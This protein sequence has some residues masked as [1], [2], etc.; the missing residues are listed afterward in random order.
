MFFI[1][2]LQRSKD[3]IIGCLGFSLKIIVLLDAY[4]KALS[5]GAF[6]LKLRRGAFQPQGT[7]LS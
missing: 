5:S 6:R 3:P 2:G 4:A 1:R 7:P